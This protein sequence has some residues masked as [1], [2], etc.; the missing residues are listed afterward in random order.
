MSHARSFIRPLFFGV[1]VAL[2]AAS[3]GALADAPAAACG[4][5]DTAVK[6]Q[7]RI[8]QGR[9]DDAI[10]IF[11]CV[12][13]AQP[14][15]LE[16]YRGRAEAELLLGRYSDA[17]RDYALVT[18]LVLPAHPEAVDAVFA[19]YDTRLAHHPKDA[20]ALTGGSFVHW[21]YF[22]YEA[23]IPMLDRLLVVRPDD[24]YGTLYRGSNRLFVGADVAGGVA[25]LD[26][27]IALAPASA[28]VRFI[29]ADAYTYAYPDPERALAEASLALAWGL[30]TPRIEAILASSSLAL[31]DVA[32]GSMHIQKH[33]ELV[34]TEIVATPA[35]AA[36]GAAALD[37]VPGRTYEIP[38]V[39]AAGEPIAI[40]TESPSGAIYD[41]IAVLLAPDGSAAIGNDDFIDYFAGFDW[42]APAAGA[43]TLRVTSFEGVSTG[44]LVVTRD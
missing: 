33:I 27:A 12:I 6:G 11:T 39:A 35:L 3:N 25:D 20:A 43:Y 29:V 1:A 38:I 19:S 34:T 31:G 4:P 42:V 24:L 32:G 10:A 36:G 13:E 21:W 28:D 14:D 5:S 16:G 8:D 18:A 26:H 44:D 2:L 30:E 37:L 41:S 15:E 7:R 23:T 17:M 40:R 9:Y 22:D